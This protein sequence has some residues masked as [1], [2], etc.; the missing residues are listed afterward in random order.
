VRCTSRR[1]NTHITESRVVLYRWHPWHGRPVYIARPLN[2]GR[3]PVFRCA[4]EAGDSVATLE[5]PQWM[6]DPA[7]CCRIAVVTDPSVDVG[8]LR[9]LRR[10]LL[11]I[12]RAEP[13][14]V[15]E[16]EHLAK[17]DRGGACAIS[18]SA[19]TDRP[20]GVVPSEGKSPDVDVLFQRSSCTDGMA[21][22]AAAATASTT[23]AQSTPPAG[24]VR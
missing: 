22:G 1:Q 10:L 23:S 20:A 4:L 17:Q 11:A 13:S 15:V 6:F 9:E 24:G 16:A 14:P 19:A 7:I 2:K 8:S 12:T 3:Q 5:V 18:E 21:A